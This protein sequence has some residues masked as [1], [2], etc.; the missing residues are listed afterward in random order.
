VALYAST[1]PGATAQQI[2]DAI[3]GSVTPTPS[4]AGITATGGRLNL[5]SIIAPA[6]VNP[7]AAPSGLT[8]AGGNAT[9]SL[10][11]SAVT[12]ATS[13]T[14]KRATTS[15]GP[16]SA[17]SSGVTSTSYSD[18]SVQNGVS[19]FYVV[20]ASNSGGESAD[21]NEASA[22]P[23]AP[24]TP[25]APTGV[26]ATVGQA[27]VS[28]TAPV[29]VRWNASTG[30]TSYTVKRATSS[31]GPFST[32]SSG[33]TT[34]IFTDNVTANGATY[35]YVISALNAGAAS[36]NSAAASVTAQTAA[37]KN[38]TATAISSSQ[39]T[40]AWLDQSSDEQG[41]KLEYSVNNYNWYQFGTLAAGRT[42]AS[43][44]GTS[45]RST[46]YFRIRAY[47][48]TA[49]TAYSNVARITMP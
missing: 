26:T 21:S 20:S 37:P 33:N 41:F 22:L 12:D 39:L 16:Y 47:N 49:N 48:G 46:Y 7:P 27:K 6:V 43:V 15:G 3:L 35:Y 32:V 30:A 25:P 4:L 34:L 5:S 38:L 18:T 44:T 23:K 1:H 24:V 31:A 45:S 19:Y 9:V 2:R 13:Y 14:V 11:W 29:T 28:G 8:A 40:L 10:N 17:V 36:P 42:S